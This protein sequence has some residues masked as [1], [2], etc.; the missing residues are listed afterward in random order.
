[1]RKIFLSI[2]LILSATVFVCAES[3]SSNGS[4]EYR[5]NGCSTEGR[6]CC[7]GVYCDWGISS[8]SSCTATSETR[9]CAGNV[10]NASGGTQTRTRTVS[11][12]C[13]GC[14]Y[15]SW[16]SWSGTCTC[17]SPYEWYT[18]YCRINCLLDQSQSANNCRECIGNINAWRR[19][20]NAC[21]CNCGSGYGWDGHYC[22]QMVNGDKIYK[23]CK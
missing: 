8:C 18:N 9:N 5:I 4:V 3:C 12:S 11:N 10:A 20:G 2:V 16:G 13:G 22:Y 1:M 17:T 19:V 6:A 15:N 7:L 14:T 23:L 21:D